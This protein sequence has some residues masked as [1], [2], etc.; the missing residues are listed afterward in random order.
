[1]QREGNG[2]VYRLESAYPNPGCA[3]LSPPRPRTGSAVTEVKTGI[4]C[5]AKD[6]Y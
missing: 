3:F 4:S 6:L 5:A 1:M 2:R